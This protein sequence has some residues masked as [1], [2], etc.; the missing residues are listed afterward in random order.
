MPVRRLTGLPGAVARRTAPT[1][2]HRP[3]DVIESLDEERNPPCS[4]IVNVIIDET[5]LSDCSCGG[6]EPQWLTPSGLLGIVIAIT[7]RDVSRR[8]STGCFCDCLVVSTTR[9][10]KPFCACRLNATNPSKQHVEN[11]TD[12]RSIDG[13]HRTTQDSTPI[14]KQGVHSCRRSI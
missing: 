8:P 5:L 2:R 10:A 4:P 1:T 14:V 7:R 12:S 3:F 6:C 9:N 11:T 13:E